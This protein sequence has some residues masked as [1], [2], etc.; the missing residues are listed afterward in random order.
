MKHP[1]CPQRAWDRG[2]A[3]H[4]PTGTTEGADGGGRGSQQGLKPPCKRQEFREERRSGVKERRRGVKERRRGVKERRSGERCHDCSVFLD[5]IQKPDVI[6]TVRVIRYLIMN[7][8]KSGVTNATSPLGH[9][10]PK[11]LHVFAH[12]SVLVHVAGDEDCGG[13]CGQDGEHTDPHHQ[14]L[15]LLRRGAVELHGAADAEERSEAQEQEA[16]ANEEVDDQRHQDEAPQVVHAIDPHVADT[17]EQ[18]ALHP[19][20]DQDDDG[21]HRRDHPGH[22]VKVLRV[23][24]DGLTTPLHPGRQVPGEG[25]DHPPD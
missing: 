22:Q 23:G 20:H 13:H 17:S 15:Q 25:Q 6:P 9:G 2:Q 18:V 5:Q 14:L 8:V 24:L 1:V 7:T 21:L 10:T 16:G 19:S 12:H 3:S 11:R 4:W